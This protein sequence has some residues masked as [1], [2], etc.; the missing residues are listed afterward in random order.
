[1][2]GLRSYATVNYLHSTE[3]VGEFRPSHIVFVSSYSNY[4]IHNSIWQLIYEVWSESNA[5]GEITTK[6]I[7][8]AD[9]LFRVIFRHS[10]RRSGRTFRSAPS[11]GK[12]RRRSLLSGWFG[13]P[14]PSSSGRS[15]ASER[16]Q[17]AWS[18]PLG[19]GRNPPG[20]DPANR[21]DGEA[22]GRPSPPDTPGPS[23]RYG[24]G[25]CPSAGTIPGT[26]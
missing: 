26:P 1:M 4:I 24:P 18:S 3:H 17:P 19:R 8:L 10:L 14:P 11:T 20:R 6:H 15:P 22:S 23:R 16:G 5:S 9:H 12:K 2:Y 21:V 7:S 13:R 25:R